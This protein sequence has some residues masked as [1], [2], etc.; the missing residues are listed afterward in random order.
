[1]TQPTARKVEKVTDQLG[2]RRD[3][4]YE[5]IKNPPAR[6]STSSHLIED[7]AREPG[8]S[9]RGGG[10]RGVYRKQIHPVLLQ[11]AAAMDTI[12]DR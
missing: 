7:S 9:W 1:M 10:H 6:T 12:F 5:L 11:G 8:R 4:I 3:K 2:A